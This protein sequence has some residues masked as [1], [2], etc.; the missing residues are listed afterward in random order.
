EH[1]ARNRPVSYHIF[2]IFP[3]LIATNKEETSNT[4]ISR[5]IYFTL[6]VFRG[7][8][9]DRSS[10][11]VLSTPLYYNVITALKNHE[12]EEQVEASTAYN[13]KDHMFRKFFNV[14]QR[15]YYLTHRCLQTY[16]EIWMITTAQS[17]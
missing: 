4:S 10:C 5:K 7:Y 12:I 9:N 3:E 1:Y 8:V 13:G 17:F 2:T 15:F 6:V 16:H 11:S 14:K